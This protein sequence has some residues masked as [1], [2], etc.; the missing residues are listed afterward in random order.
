M[1]SFVMLFG[2]ILTVFALLELVENKQIP[3][4]EIEDRFKY[5]YP[6]LWG[7]YRQPNPFKWGLQRLRYQKTRILT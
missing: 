7:T 6:E 3:M 4:F 5:Y 1:D 2:I